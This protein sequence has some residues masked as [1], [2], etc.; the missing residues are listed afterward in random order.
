MVRIGVGLFPTQ[1]SRFEGIV[2]TEGFQARLRQEFLK[3]KTEEHLVKIV[4]AAPDVFKE[5]YT[6]NAPP[7]GELALAARDI[8][9]DWQDLVLQAVRGAFDRTGSI[10]QNSSG[11]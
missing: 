4:T 5:L 8:E 2:A 10:P 3:I 6:K 9:R 7:E 11:V 1:V